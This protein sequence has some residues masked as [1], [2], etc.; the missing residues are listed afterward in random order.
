VYPQYHELKDRLDAS[1]A[2]ARR[3]ADDLKTTNQTE[4]LAHL[5]EQVLAFENVCGIL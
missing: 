5:Q 2:K 3:L 4:E 1:E